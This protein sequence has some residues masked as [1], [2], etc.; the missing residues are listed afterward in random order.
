MKG[1]SL[2]S[3]LH[4]VEHYER[5]RKGVPFFKAFRTKPDGDITSFVEV[6]RANC[7]LLVINGDFVDFDLIANQS[8]RD[9]TSESLARLQLAY[10]NHRTVFDAL[11]EFLKSG[12]AV[13][14]VVGNHDL[15]W[16]RPKVRARLLE[17]IW[18]EKVE[19]S[20]IRFFDAPS[21][22]EILKSDVPRIFFYPF[23]FEIKGLLWAE[24]GHF[25]DPYGRWS[26]YANPWLDSDSLFYPVGSLV[27][28]Y[29]TLLMWS[30][31]PF[32]KKQVLGGLR[33]YLSHYIKYYSFPSPKAPINGLVGTLKVFFDS[34]R[35]AKVWNKSSGK[36]DPLDEN[37]LAPIAIESPTRLFRT[38]WLDRFI[39]AALGLFSAIGFAVAP[40]E[41]NPKIFGILASIG[42][43]PA[44][45]LIFGT[46]AKGRKLAP[47]INRIKSAAQ[48][49]GEHFFVFSH[50]HMPLRVELDGTTLLNPGC[51]APMYEDVECRKLS[52]YA[53]CGLIIEKKGDF[54]V[55]RFMRVAGWTIEEFTPFP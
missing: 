10:E 4:L 20:D 22:F 38:L 14:L 1:I 31:N 19:G 3:D 39:V 54:W 29:L 33:S 21:G 49:R 18:G 24:H 27:N 47:Y 8:E 48:K 13:A 12:G 32:M 15:D 37:Y 2:I 41:I 11:R 35:T 51:F 7:E 30:F 6:A 50:T 40:V 17:L 25:F 16:F 5:E 42:A 34:V 53:R 9:Q 46:P 26:D 36:T 44:Y 45:E 28:R 43:L 52:P 23:G 55:P